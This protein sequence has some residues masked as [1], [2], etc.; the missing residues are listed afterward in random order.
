M[1][2]MTCIIL[3]DEPLAAALL[4]EYISQVPYL[5][6]K[7]QYRDA[8]SA[9]GHLQQEMV[10]LVFLDI[11]LPGLK[12]FDFLRTIPVQPTVIVTTAY[13]QYAVEGFELNI[14]DYLLKPFSFERFAIAVRKAY[15]R[16]DAA[17]PAALPEKEDGNV[18]VLTVDRKKLLI[19][20]DNILYIESQR[21]YVKVVTTNGVYQSKISTAEIESLLPSSRFCRIHR[22]FIVA[23]DKVTGYSKT[24][25]LVGGQWLPIGRSYRGAA[26]MK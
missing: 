15:S 14:T 9:A 20:L 16:F 17:K 18:L 7:G 5:D 10:D 3:E 26:W 24:Q 22:S 21:E 13:P 6:L 19:D 12:G 8:R 23:L 2:K 11:H 4:A 1:R 25:A